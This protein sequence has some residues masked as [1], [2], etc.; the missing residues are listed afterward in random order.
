MKLQQAGMAEVMNSKL[1]IRQ[2]SSDCALPSG[3]GPRSAEHDVVKALLPCRSCQRSCL[4]LDSMKK[5]GIGRRLFSQL[6]PSPTPRSYG[7]HDPGP[8]VVKD[9]QNPVDQLQIKYRTKDRNPSGWSN[10]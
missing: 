6:H 10:L 3:C 5:A 1:S 8:F 2:C 9:R 4:V 7:I